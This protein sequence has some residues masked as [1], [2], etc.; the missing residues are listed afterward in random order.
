M[1]RHG[2]SSFV[3]L[4]MQML[5]GASDRGA[6]SRTVAVATET[7]APAILPAQARARP[8]THRWRC[9]PCPAPP[10]KGLTKVSPRNAELTLF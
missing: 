8:V 6:R 4:V 9:P 10:A 3:A 1:Q 7:V 2:A 5:P